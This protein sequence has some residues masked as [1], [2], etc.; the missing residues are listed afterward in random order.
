MIARRCK[1]PLFQKISQQFQQ[2]QGK[3]NS[4]DLQPVLWSRRYPK[5]PTSGVLAYISPSIPP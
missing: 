4:P 5:I 3:I 1:D 2:L